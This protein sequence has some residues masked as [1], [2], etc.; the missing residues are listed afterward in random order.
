MGRAGELGYGALALVDRDGVSG[1]PRSFEAAKAAGVRP[2]VGAA[3]TLEDGGRPPILVE[4]Q[5]G[6][7]NLCQLVTRTK[8][9]VAKGKG[10]LDLAL[11]ETQ[12]LVGLIALPGAETL[13]RSPDTDRL[14]RIVSVF[15]ARNVA[16]G[17]QRH[18]WRE[19]E[20]ANQTLLHF[21][22]ALCLTAVTT[23]GVRHATVRGR[24]LLDALTCIREKRT[25][26]TAGHLFSENAEQ[27]LKAP[28][29]MAALF[30]DRP[31][32][33]RATEGLAER[34][35]FA[36]DDLGYRLRLSRPVTSTCASTP[37]DCA[38]PRLF[39]GRASGVVP[40]SS[41]AATRHRP[42]G[43]QGLWRRCKWTRLT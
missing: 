38:I 22:D 7:R 31:D 33:L 13:G 35:A 20:V 19:Q 23:N 11:L 15:G 27:Q 21:A 40:L 36:L 34:L 37:S 4:S 25:L 9:S 17:V 30:S 28:R 14:A 41:S 6:Y 42:C 2:L 18:R 24:S 10:S 5:R 43:V 16:I 3:L 1:A 8:A 26:A 29:A 32:L 12:D 39:S